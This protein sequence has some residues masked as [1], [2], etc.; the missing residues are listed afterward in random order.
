[1]RYPL[2][3]GLTVL[4]P[5]TMEPVPADG[6]T[7]GEIMFRG[8]IVMKGYLKNPKATEEAF[9]GGWFHTGDL[10]VMHPTATSRSRTAPRTSSSPAARTSPRSR[11]R[12]CCTAPGG[13]GRR[14]GRA[15]R[16][17]NGARCPAPS[18]S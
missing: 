1:V 6:E 17:R 3:E 8:N 16:T 5:E 4:D 10:G 7:M 12:T 11:S 14:R 15:S 13:D 18:S 9:A 2:L